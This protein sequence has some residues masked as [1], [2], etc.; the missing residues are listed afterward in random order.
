M[1]EDIRSLIPAWLAKYLP[2]QFCADAALMQAGMKRHWK[3]WLAVYLIGVVAGAFALQ[4]F[5]PKVG[6]GRSFFVMAILFVGLVGTVASAWF[7]YQKYTGP[8]GM[9]NYVIFVASIFAG[10][11]MGMIV[12]SLGTGGPFTDVDAHKLGLLFGIVTVV[13][14]VLVLAIAGI[15]RARSR[16]VAREMAVLQAEADRERLAR[17]SVQAELKLLQAQVEPH[18]LFNT[19]ANLR[20][21]VQ[22]QSPH[23][24]PMLDHLI[25]Y[26]RTA[27]PEIRA[28]SSTVEREIELARAYLEILRIRMGGALEIS[29]EVPPDLAKIAFPPLMLLTLVENAIKHGIA[30][31]GRGRIDLRVVREG[32]RLQMRVEDD[33]RGLA[34][35]IGQG[36]GLGNVRERLRAIHGES[37]R[38][39]LT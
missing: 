15:S 5:V 20:F 13:G 30:P 7:G 33:G 10:G 34:E 35:P 17:Q 12:E 8:R 37:A 29:T 21:L 9:R 32:G 14:A 19:L 26:L 36:V 3:A 31:V 11:V 24:L 23:A 39:D 28:E 25:H 16:Q 18:F 6:L 22:T 27:L 38:L 4:A 1:P 2:A